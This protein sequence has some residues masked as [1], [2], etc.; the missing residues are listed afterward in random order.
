MVLI[1]CIGCATDTDRSLRIMTYNTAF[2][3]APADSGNSHKYPEFAAEMSKKILDQDVDVVVLNEVFDDAMKDAF[4]DDL[5]SHFPSYVHNLDENDL[6]S[7]SGLMLF[8]RYKLGQLDGGVFFQ[9]SIVEF[10]N[11]GHPATVSWEPFAG[12]DLNDS[13]WLSN[14]GIA[15]VRILN[16]SYNDAPFNV[17]FTHMQSTTGDQTVDEKWE[18][19]DDRQQELKTIRRSIEASVWGDKRRREPIFLAGD[20]NIDGNLLNPNRDKVYDCISNSGGTVC[21]ALNYTEWEY[22]FDSAIPDRNDGFY[23][24]DAGPCTYDLST[25]VP[26]GSLLVDSWG[27][28]T[29]PNDPGQSQSGAAPIWDEDHADKGQRL[30][31][32]LHN[33]PQAFS[34]TGAGGGA[35]LCMQYIRRGF[36]GANQFAVDLGLS[37]HLPIIADFNAPA[38]RCSPHPRIGDPDH[39]NTFGPGEVDFDLTNSGATNFNYVSYMGTITH[40]GSMQW[41][42]LDQPI[43]GSIQILGENVAYQVYESSDLSTPIS[44][45]NGNCETTTLDFGHEIESLECDFNMT[46]P[47]YYV[48][49]FAVDTAMS[50]PK[51]KE[52]RTLSDIDYWINFR[53][54]TCSSIEDACM[55]DPGVDRTERWPVGYLS[56]GTQAPDNDTMFFRFATEW[57]TAGLAPDISFRLD[58]EFPTDPNPL[59]MSLV[60]DQGNIVF[61]NSDPAGFASQLP[62][63]TGWNA[64]GDG[65][66]LP[67]R[68]AIPNADGLPGFP[69]WPRPYYLKVHRNSLSGPA[70]SPPYVSV[71]KSITVR[72][73][74][75]LTYFRPVVLMCGEERTDIGGD[76]FRAEFFFDGTLKGAPLLPG[77]WF[78]GDS[79]PGTIPGTWSA[80]HSGSYVNQMRPELWED[81]LD[82]DNYP[83]ETPSGATIAPLD[84][85]LDMKDNPAPLDTFV[86][87]DESDPDDAEYWYE[88]EYRRSHMRPA[89]QSD[90]ECSS[91][92]TC[93]NGACQ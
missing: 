68:T 69:D 83:F 86:Y 34:F 29:S 48:R 91:G 78:D 6:D 45:W 18:D 36:A 21:S 82:E 65:D 19:F 84:K 43:S 51:W 67:D 55:L 63:A 80:E 2:M 71:D 61:P 35:S 33:K 75:S 4:V 39:P 46:D 7:D 8:S 47:P 17:A 53:R 59:S 57:S 14:K 90:T 89:C 9:N 93:L 56:P 26:T 25:P 38:Q 88:L 3:V 77:E 52:V 10:E 72:F 30:D 87:A 81:V 64:D 54:Y 16:E 31:Y 23:A 12:E 20:L 85:T 11:Q 44:P 13:D 74:T 37:D 60:D 42:V 24:C 62:S 58:S 49:V 41:Y 76:D 28:E 5:K 15:V 22:T 70:N 66:G 1:A 50:D 40:R 73:E 32:I 79:F 92:N 27:Y